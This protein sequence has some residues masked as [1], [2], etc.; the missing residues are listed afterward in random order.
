VK[1]TISLGSLNFV[2]LFG[3]LLINGNSANE[4]NI[5]ARNELNQ[6]HGRP[7]LGKEMYVR[8]LCDKCLIPAY[9]NDNVAPAL[10]VCKEE[11]ARRIYDIFIREK[12]VGSM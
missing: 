4:N 1:I 12:Y 10:F 5:W 7:D 9:D 3:L 8:H 2:C 6:A 11:V